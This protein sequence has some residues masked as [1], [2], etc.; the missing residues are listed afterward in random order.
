MASREARER[1]YKVIKAAEMEARCWAILNI[2]G[3]F[4]GHKRQEHVVRAIV[5]ALENDAL[6]V[7]EVS[8]TNG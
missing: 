8:E 3:N 4:V 6:L 2:K 7:E 5:E 1:A